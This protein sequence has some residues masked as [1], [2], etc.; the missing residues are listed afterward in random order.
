MTI[1]TGVVRGLGVTAG[2]ADVNVTTQPCSTA[3]G[4]SAHCFALLRRKYMAAAIPGAV[5]FK[6]LLD[7]KHE[8]HSYAVQWAGNMHLADLYQMQIEASSTDIRVTKQLFD[9]EEIYSV[10]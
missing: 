9:V 7:F 10:L 2:G 4:N 3:I 6:D 1:A 8:R 5:L